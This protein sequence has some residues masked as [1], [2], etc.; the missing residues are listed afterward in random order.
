MLRESVE[1]NSLFFQTPEETEDNIEGKDVKVVVTFEEDHEKM[2]NN[3]DELSEGGI[4]VKVKP[5]EEESLVS[6]SDVKEGDQ[7][8]DTDS[9]CSIQES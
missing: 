5:C 6:G 8:S 9:A 7:V 3:P 1:I 4:D 2:E